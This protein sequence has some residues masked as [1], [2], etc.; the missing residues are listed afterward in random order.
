MHEVAPIIFLLVVLK[1]PVF[2]G[3]WLIYSALR[4]DPVADG[5]EDEGDDHGFRRW[6]REPG[7]DRG[8]RRGPHGGGAVSLADCP[9]GGRVR[10]KARSTTRTPVTADRR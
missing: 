10:T 8:P 6:R 7:P 3:M 1:V 2:Y 4:D 9:P 5:I